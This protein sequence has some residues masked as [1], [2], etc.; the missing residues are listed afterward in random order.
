MADTIRSLADL[1]Q[2]FADNTLGVI[3]AQDIRDLMVSLMVHGEIGSG[4][5]ASITISAAYQPVDLTVAGVVGRGLNVDTAN[6][7]INGIPVSMKAAIDAEVNFTGAN[8]TTYDFAVHVN[9]VAQPR[10]TASCRI[11]SATQIGSIHMGSSLQLEPGDLV[12]LRV[13]SSGAV[14]F[15]LQRAALRVKRLGVE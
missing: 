6:K 13:K 10:L 15:V 7:R 11:V 4:A 1:N 5:K 14:A 2:R 3:S 12:D 9:G 8:S